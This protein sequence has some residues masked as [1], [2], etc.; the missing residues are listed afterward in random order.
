MKVRLLRQ[1]KEHSTCF[2]RHYAL[3]DLQLL[4]IWTHRHVSSDGT[5]AL[6]WP[7]I[8]EYV[9][10]ANLQPTSLACFCL[11]VHQGHLSPLL[12][13]WRRQ[14]K[15]ECPRTGTNRGHCLF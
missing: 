8:P 14:E 1:K 7:V 2:T 11:K 12:V 4:H 10:A 6:A 3:A 13:S 15:G 9:I 5:V